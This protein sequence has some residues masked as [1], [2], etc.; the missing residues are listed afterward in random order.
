M[1]LHFYGDSHLRPIRAAY[2]A[3]MFGS[4]PCLFES[5]GGA[6]AVGLRHPK[7]KTQALNIYR[8]SLLP[9]RHNVVPVFQLGEV[10]CGFVIW[11][12]AQ[13]H[14]ESVRQQLEESLAA[15]LSFL[16]EIRDAGYRNLLVTSAMLP[17][18]IDGQLDGEVANLRREVKATLRERTDLTLYY[19]S[20]LARLCQE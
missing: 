19:N 12:R 10:D 5:V 6:T 14:G 9:Y 3:G 20:K 16:I 11:V 8:N 17:T 13:R 4:L 18:I 1:T 7:S 2:E 15:Y